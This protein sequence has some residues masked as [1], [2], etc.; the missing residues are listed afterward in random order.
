MKHVLNLHKLTT[1]QVDD[2]LTNSLSNAFHIQVQKFSPDRET[3][4]NG[5][6]DIARSIHRDRFRKLNIT[7]REGQHDSYGFDHWEF[8]YSSMEY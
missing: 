2:I 8:C 7:F 6:M 1:E 3:I 5:V 4:T